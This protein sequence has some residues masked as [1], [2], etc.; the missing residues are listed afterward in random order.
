MPMPYWVRVVGAAA[1]GY[2]LGSLSPAYFLGAVAAA[3]IELL[4]MGLD[5][6]LTVG[7]GSAGIVTLLL[8]I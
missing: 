3:A 5:D 8:L 1:V 7:L 6:N 2:L 4:S